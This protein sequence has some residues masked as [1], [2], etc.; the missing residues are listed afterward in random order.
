MAHRAVL[1]CC[2]PYLFEIFNGDIET[3]GISHITFEDLNPDAI[4]ILLNYA[5]TAQLVS[6]LVFL[7]S[8]SAWICTELFK[9]SEN[10]C[11]VTQAES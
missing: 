6:V 7:I 8:D 2:S 1:A 5:Y 9:T 4:E 10:L 3:P 11:F